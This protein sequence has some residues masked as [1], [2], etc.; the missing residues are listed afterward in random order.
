MHHV[1]ASLAGVSPSSIRPVFRKH[2]LSLCLSAA[3]AAPLLASQAFASPS[4]PQN[5]VVKNCNDSG[6]DSL[7]DI[8]ENPMKAKTG[9][10]VDLSQL[11]VPCGMADSTIT[12]GSEIAVSQDDLTLNGPSN[13]SVTISAGGMSRV[14]HHTG[15]GTFALF[16]LTVVDGYYHGANDVYGGCIES[17]GG[18]VSLNHVTVSHCT[19][20]S[21]IGYSNGAG[22]SAEFGNVTLIA[23]KVTGNEAKI[24]ANDLRSGFGGG[25]YSGGW[26]FA[27]YSSI[28]DNKADGGGTGGGVAAA[29]GGTFIASSVDNNESGYGGGITTFSATTIID[30]T[31]SQN[32]ASVV[33]GGIYAD[34]ADSF[35]L[36]N[37]T[38]AQNKAGVIGGGIWFGGTPGAA[39]LTSNSSIIANNNSAAA[40]TP[41]DI[42]ILAGYGTLAGADNLVIASN[43]ADPVVITVTSDPKLGSLQF[44]G[45][46]TKTLMLLPG[47]PAF[48]KGNTTGMF[49][50]ITTDQRGPGYPRTSGPSASV[51]LGAVQFDSI[52]A[53]GFNSPF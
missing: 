1:H 3:L 26:T 17:D 39:T 48:G 13:G 2:A 37:S 9:D 33:G 11:A 53:D 8:I 7:R 47:S 49:P 52:F 12:L 19:A 27:W 34:Y 20:M 24:A 42:Y 18:D 51:D 25:V 31:I 6:T 50:S 15:A 41:D 14:F 28:S 43:V 36:A 38:I 10:T 5:W 35:Q 45:G 46:P 40:N 44:N 4:S 23:S 29:G 32:E 21:D 30:C 16:G 22:V